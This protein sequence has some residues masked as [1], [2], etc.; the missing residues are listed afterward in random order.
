MKTDLIS[1]IVPVYGVEAYLSEC[2]DSILAQTYQTLEVI[3]VD[4]G[5]PDNCG[6]IC[7]AYASWDS[8]VKVIHKPN[9]G[10]ASAR[11]MGLDTAGGEYI[12]LIDSDDWVSPHYVEKLYRQLVD[13]RADV[14]VCSFANVYRDGRTENP[15]AYPPHAIMTQVEF[16][17]RFLTDWTSGMATNKMFRSYLLEDVRYAE[18]HKIDDEFF[19]YRAIMNCCRVVMFDEPL[20]LYRMR[21]SSVMTAAGQ[22]MERMLSD[23]LEYLELRY[24]H[25]CERYPTLKEKFFCNLAQN[26][27]R[28]RFLGGTYPDFLRTVKQKMRRYFL[29][30]LFSAM[31]IREKY[32]Y[33]RAM[34]LPGSYRSDTEQAPGTEH[35]FQCYE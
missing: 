14:S 11:N 6:D 5:S 10:A 9:G 28:L 25:I 19:T 22:Y 17:E 1:I 13:N 34:M 2:I 16:L 7:D 31:G 8:R 18:G 24:M 33:V 29:K 3:L 26:L 21:A 23:K 4:D 32:A 12:C 30:T 27:L 35:G 20:Y 15:I